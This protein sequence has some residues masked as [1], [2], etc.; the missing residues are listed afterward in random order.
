MLLSRVLTC[1]T[2]VYKSNRR[3]F[4]GR[5]KQY[6]LWLQVTMHDIVFV[7]IGHSLEDLLEAETNDLAGIDNIGDHAEMIMEAARTEAARRALRV[8]ETSTTS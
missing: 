6:I 4:I 3:V 7:E 5:F 8:G 2:K 1:K